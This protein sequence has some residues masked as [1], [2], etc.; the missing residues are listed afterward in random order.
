MHQPLEEPLTANTG[1]P[2]KYII[3]DVGIEEALGARDP[4][5]FAINKEV[6]ASFILKKVSSKCRA[7]QF[8]MLP[9]SL[10]PLPN[11]KGLYSVASF[12]IVK[13]KR[14]NPERC[15]DPPLFV[16]M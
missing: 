12:A 8:E 10:P 9:T 16:Q 13:L 1:I 14:P 3:Q 7:P 4:L 11:D 2:G 15:G 5:N 6:L